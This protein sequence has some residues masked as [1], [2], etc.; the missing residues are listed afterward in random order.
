MAD[1]RTYEGMFLV[2]PGREF[3]AASEP[4]RTVL[5]R[6]EGD[7]LSAKPWDERRLAYDIEGHKRALYV[8]TYFKLDPD[9]VGELERDIHLSEG[10]IRALVLR[11]D[12]LS[13]EVINAE[14]PATSGQR[15]IGPREDDRAPDGEQ[16]PKESAPAA[17]DV[18]AAEAT[19]E[20]ASPAPVADDRA[21]ADDAKDDSAQ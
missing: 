1:K 9:K 14:T 19:S 10:I 15:R 17:A 3:E 6:S 21:A 13:D 18:P 8:L 12:G 5:G 16:A 4:I 2:E 11:K 7:L 20:A